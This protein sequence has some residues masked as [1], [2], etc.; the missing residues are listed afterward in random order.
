MESFLKDQINFY[1]EFKNWY[2]EILKDFGFNYEKDCEARNFLSEILDL[3]GDNWNLERLLRIISE[4]FQD[5]E[6]ILIYGCGPS[7]EET[8][9]M[10]I[11]EFGENFFKKCINLAADGASILLRERGIHLEAIFSDLDGITKNEFN[12]A[13][14]LIIHAHGD[15][16]EMINSF[17]ENIVNFPNIIGTTQVE[18]IDNVINP[19]GF[20]DGDR[21]L[22]FI[23]TLLKPHNKLY[24]IG[25]DFNDII[26]KYSKPSLIEHYLG[27]PT[28]IKK[29]NYAVKLI[30]WL[31]ERISNNLFFLNSKLSSKRFKYLTIEEFSALVKK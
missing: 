25:M 14:F 12:Y 9:D 22:F 23:R 8:V 31:T 20:T 26:G 7:L 1:V 4:K 16:L 24:L 27:P 28:K 19:G 10:L 18:P 13:E 3:K 5:K 21:I 17:K 29:L 2:F 6:I 30:E 11:K 15:N